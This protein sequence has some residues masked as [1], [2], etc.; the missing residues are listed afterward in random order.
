MKISI[1]IW[2]PFL[3]LQKGN[4]CQTG[5][6]HKRLPATFQHINS[7]ST[8]E[9]LKI[10]SIENVYVIYAK[11]NDSIVKIMSKK[12]G[13]YNCN[14]IIKGGF[15]DLQIRSHLPKY[16]YQKLDIGGTRYNST[17]I[18]LEDTGGVI[19]DLFVT[20]NLNGLCFIKTNGTT[21]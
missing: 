18:Y 8:F 14:P 20:D 4:K 9:I 3:L 19:W 1:L 6:E 2:I 7:D 12:N 11:R 15:Y 16:T 13:L 17:T 21:R 10:D 5:Q